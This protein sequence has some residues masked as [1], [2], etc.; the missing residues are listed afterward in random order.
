MAI[1]TINSSAL[2]SLSLNGQGD[3]TTN[4][5]SIL[6]KDD[7]LKLLLTELQYQDPTS[8][9]D[10]EKILSQTS[11]LATLEAQQN[12]N[13]TLESLMKSLEASSAISAIGAIGKYAKMG[14]K[15]KVEKGRDTVFTVNFESPA[16]KGSIKIYNETGEVVKTLPI[17]E[18]SNSDTV[19]KWDGKDENGNQ[20]KDGFYKVSGDYI[21]K[22]G[23]KHSV[24]FGTFP[25]EGV[26]FENG[27]ALLKLGGQYVPMDN[28]A[29]IF[30]KKG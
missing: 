9:M 26:S 10:T 6:G 5:K 4:P 27:K 21:D 3:T 12:T 20:V 22:N 24:E 25:I 13:K 7:F 2:S 28:I 18:G 19:F 1:D 30:E 15:I 16:K 17:P 14:N 23:E 8:P 29:E 11:E